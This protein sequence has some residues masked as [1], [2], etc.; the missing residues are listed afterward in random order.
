MHKKHPHYFVYIFGEQPG[1]DVQIG[2]ADNLQQHVA[3]K[4]QH[5]NVLQNM[6]NMHKL[7]YYE[8]YDVEE[9]ALNRERQIKSGDQNST[10]NLIASMNPN[11]LDLSDTL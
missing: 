7:V 6:G 10:Y 11:W 4:R 9:V 1:S 8:H 5:E 3:Q 2:I